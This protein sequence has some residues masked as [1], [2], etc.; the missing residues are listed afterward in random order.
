MT[1]KSI[2]ANF[3]ASANE[4]QLE[5][6]LM[7][8]KARKELRRMQE[9]HAQERQREA[10]E[11]QARR[12]KDIEAAERALRTGRQKLDH[13]PPWVLPMKKEREADV[14]AA[15]AQ[16]RVDARNAAAEQEPGREAG[17]HRRA[18]EVHRRE[19]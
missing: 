19:L 6:F 1:D 13:R 17:H 9:A 14:Q 16:R 12:E 18:R 2:G 3:S 5:I 15:E 4:R 10:A 7:S 8:D 11:R